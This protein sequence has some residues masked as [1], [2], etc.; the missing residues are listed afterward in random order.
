[1]VMMVMT[2]M[3]M[4]MVMMVVK[5]LPMHIPLL[6]LSWSVLVIFWTKFREREFG[7]FWEDYFIWLI[8]TI[9]LKYNSNSK[10]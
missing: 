1:M 2:V 10:L 5:M 6:M 8:L 3:M 4:V 7:F 9:T